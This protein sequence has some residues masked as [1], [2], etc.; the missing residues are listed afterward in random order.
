MENK[1][2]AVLFILMLCMVTAVS[3]CGKQPGEQE[4]STLFENLS[5]KDFAGRKVGKQ[6]L[7][8]QLNMIYVWASWCSPCIGEMPELDELAEEYAQE[9]TVGIYGMVV[10]SDEKTGG[11]IVGLSAKERKEVQRILEKTG[12]S[13]P[14][15][16]VSE[17]MVKALANLEGFPTTLFVDQEGKLV[18]GPVLG[19][20]SKEEWKKEIA[21]RL[22]MLK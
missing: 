9:G 12:V 21:E 3:G 5:T 1:R 14:Q 6:D 8:Q 2:T 7:A 18:G 19:A 4:F 10:E 15:I 17:Q 16:L 13:Y 20:F 22:E 11:I